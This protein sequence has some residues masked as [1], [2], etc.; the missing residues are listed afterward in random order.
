MWEMWK[1]D[2]RMPMWN[3]FVWI[4]SSAEVEQSQHSGKIAIVRTIENEKAAVK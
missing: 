4:Y 2:E 3:G 1:Y